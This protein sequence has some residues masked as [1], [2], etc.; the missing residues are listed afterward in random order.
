MKPREDQCSPNLC[1][2][3][4]E[5]LNGKFQGIIRQFSC[6]N[7]GIFYWDDG[8]FYLGQWKKNKIHGKGIFVYPNGSY[9][10]SSFY[11]DQLNGLTIMR[12]VSGHLMI[13]NWALNKKN[14][15]FLYYDQEEN[16]WL[17]CRHSQKKNDVNT[18]LLHEEFVKGKDFYPKFLDNFPALKEILQ[19]NVFQMLNEDL[20]E[21]DS[22]FIY[23][24]MKKEE[25]ELAIFSYAF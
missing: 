14:G 8:C 23:T 16:L 1:N 18:E 20:K 25:I 6:E 3:S 9:L 19:E 2:Q 12:L 11:K 21:R 10:Y 24:K 7:T 5:Y 17:L 13:G 4:L 15:L 22:S